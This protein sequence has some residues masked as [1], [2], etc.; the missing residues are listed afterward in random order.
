[1]SATARCHTEM[2]LSELR[3]VEGVNILLTH[4]G[5]G[6]EIFPVGG[7]SLVHIGGYLSRPLLHLGS[8]RV[9]VRLMQ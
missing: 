8:W 5:G 1:M 6:P 9:L 3:W 4:I 2:L 7:W